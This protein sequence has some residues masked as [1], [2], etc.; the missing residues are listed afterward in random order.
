MNKNYLIIGLAVALSLL[1]LS[2]WKN[3]GSLIPGKSNKNVGLS[4]GFYNPV[5]FASDEW[6][7]STFSG[8]HNLYV[9]DDMSKSPMKSS[10][11]WKHVAVNGCGTSLFPTPYIAEIRENEIT[12]GLQVSNPTART[13]FVKRDPS[14]K[15]KLDSPAEECRVKSGDALSSVIEISSGEKFLELKM[16]KGSPKII[17]ESENYG[18]ELE[19]N[20]IRSENNQAFLTDHA[21]N[22]FAVL[23]SGGNTSENKYVGGIQVISY[24]PDNIDRDE[25]LKALTPNFIIPVVSLDIDENHLIQKF[26]FD[27]SEPYVLLPHHQKYLDSKTEIY[28]YK[29]S[30]P[31]GKLSLI[32]SNEIVLKFPLQVPDIFP[33]VSLS[34]DE[35]NILRPLLA[36]DV[37]NVEQDIKNEDGVY[38]KGKTLSRYAN[39]MYVADLIDNEDTKNKILSALKD[40]LGDWFEYSGEEDS[41][42]FAYDESAGSLISSK[43]EFGHEE[44]N[45][46]HF[47][48]G[49]YLYAM[50]AISKYDREFAG[51]YS[52]MVEYLIRD[53]ASFDVEDPSFPH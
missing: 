44:L 13:I 1:A 18:W 42:Y 34:N 38:W 39:L 52:G 8:E 20:Q 45:D 49:Y 47:H 41:K 5:V 26:S 7:L 40:E 50:A 33:D 21:G 17:V 25:Y 35:K 9:S 36:T 16:V 51:K 30:T 22:E 15:I 12:I 10:A 2:V 37:E 27:V 3:G 23:S 19:S 24:I 6:K 53:V 48:Y 28:D 29:V 11:W 14:L 46:H 32:V 31:K 43:P 4:K